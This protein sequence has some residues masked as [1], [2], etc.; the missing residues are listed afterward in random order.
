[1]PADVELI[2]RDAGVG[3]AEGDPGI[4]DMRRGDEGRGTVALGGVL[5]TGDTTRRPGVVE[6]E[7]A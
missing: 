2:E 1:M 6:D 4:D 3:F 7:V 5:V